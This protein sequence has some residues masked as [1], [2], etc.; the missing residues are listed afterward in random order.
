MNLAN[1]LGFQMIQKS[2]ANGLAQSTE[3]DDVP[4]TIY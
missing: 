2:S 1:R 4:A 3:I